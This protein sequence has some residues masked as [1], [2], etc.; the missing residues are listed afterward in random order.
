MIFGIHCNAFFKQT[1]NFPKFLVKT[2]CEKTWYK[3]QLHLRLHPK[4]YVQH[5]VIPCA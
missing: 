5:Q 1:S 2:S 4:K 3:L